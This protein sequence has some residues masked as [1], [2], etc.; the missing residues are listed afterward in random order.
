MRGRYTPG[1]AP[2]TAAF[3]GPH[4]LDQERLP[5]LLQPV[6]ALDEFYKSFHKA[7]FRRAI[8]DIV[9]EGDRQIEHVARFDALLDD[10]W[11]A[12]DATDEPHLDRLGKISLRG[13]GRMHHLGVGAAHKTQ[14]VII[15]I[16]GGTVT[17]IHQDTGKS[18]ANTP[19]DP[20]RIYWA[21]NTNHPADGH[22]NMN[23]DSTQI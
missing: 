20:D 3:S 13:A 15:L 23:N 14:P 19:I 9:V 8:H 2:H 18:S 12:S 11:R 4:C 1:A 17:V 5:R 22:T 7:R 10:G 21:T 6:S 16:D